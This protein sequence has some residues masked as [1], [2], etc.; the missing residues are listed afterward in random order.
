MSGGWRLWL[1]G[2]GE[3]SGRV[4]EAVLRRARLSSGETVVDLGAGTGLLSLA[5]AREVG[6]R[7]KIYAVDSDPGCLKLLLESA[8]AANL[9]NVT[10]MQCDLRYVP[11]GDGTLDA[12]IA[13]SA[14]VYTGDVTACAK[15]IA[16][17]AGSAGRF[18]VCEPLLGEIEWRGGPAPLVAELNGVEAVLRERRGAVSLAREQMRDAFR[19]GGL[20]PDSL[21]VSYRLDFAGRSEEEIVDDYLHDLPGGFSLIETLA[22][23]DRFTDDYPV[24]LAGRL[25]GAVR[26]RSVEASLPCIFLWGTGSEN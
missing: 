19:E 10:S 1:E 20:S 15:E 3:L 8:A 5:A 4:S 7:G 9:T 14:L 17:L 24:A 21:I 6:G 16:R 26:R 11:L 13:R 22:D 23:D 12:V 2:Q 18:S 25:A